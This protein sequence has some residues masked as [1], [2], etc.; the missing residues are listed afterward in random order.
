MKT[1]LDESLRHSEWFIIVF[2]FSHYNRNRDIL[3]FDTVEEAFD[4]NT[5]EQLCSSEGYRGYFC[6]QTL[7]FAQ[8]N[9]EKT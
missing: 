2:D 3:V 4:H 6:P 8:G 7:F 9:V 5:V 1:K